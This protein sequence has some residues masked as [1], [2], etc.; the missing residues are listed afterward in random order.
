M[1]MLGARPSQRDEDELSKAA[2]IGS[3]ADDDIPY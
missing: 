3:N 2:P 1:Q